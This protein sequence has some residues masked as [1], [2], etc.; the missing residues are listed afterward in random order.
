ME[1]SIRNAFNLP[2]QDLRTYTP[3]TLAFVGD[4]VYDLVIRTVLLEEGNR[5][6]NEI[7]KKKST[8]VKAETQ[9]WIAEYF[10]KEGIFTE[11]EAEW[12]RKGKNAKTQSHAKN[13]N[14]STYHR[15]TGL[16][17]V[18]GALYIK[19]DTNRI[20]TLCK[21]GTDAFL[22]AETVEE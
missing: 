1:E 8:L 18:M 15:A 11:E 19:N 7:H 21:I 6:L 2:E 14:L 16:E 22:K 4:N 9:A 10:L 17:T 3:L 12:Y 5:K 13:A 20:I